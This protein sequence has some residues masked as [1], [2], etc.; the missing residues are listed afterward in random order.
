M[1]LILETGDENAGQVISIPVPGRSS[2]LVVQA[3]SAVVPPA[4]SGMQAVWGA[5]GYIIGASRFL[6]PWTVNVA[7][8][9]AATLFW[10]TPDVDREVQHLRA[11][12]AIA[13]A[14]DIDL[15]LLV[16]ATPGTLASQIAFILPAGI[17][18]VEVPALSI[19]VIGGE[20][21]ALSM[22]SGTAITN[23]TNMLQVLAA[24]V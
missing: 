10:I 20:Y 19:P 18:T 13:H 17:L 6:I 16:G 9:P 21:M 11:T 14:A 12:I 24:L 1:A 23:G 8:N 4:T 15:E 5:N 7:A 22:S 2:P 3:V